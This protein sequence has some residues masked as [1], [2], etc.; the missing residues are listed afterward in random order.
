MR[1]LL[2]SFTPIRRAVLRHR[3]NRGP[4]S[5]S[6]EAAILRRLADELETN[7]FVE[8]GFHPAEFNCSLLLGDHAGLLIDGDRYV[9]EDARAVLTGRLKIKQQ[10]LT[11]ESMAA[12][13]REFLDPGIFSIDVD[14][15]DY[16]FLE[17]LLPYKPKV[18]C[19]EYNGSLLDHPISTPYDP[20]FDR[21]RKHPTGWYHGASLAALA[22]LCAAHG[23][24][25]EAVS[26]YGGNAFFTERGNLDPKAA[27]KPTLLRDNAS[28]RTATEQWAAIKDMPF[29]RV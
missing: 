9:V 18:I 12:I 28:R 29:E 26:L 8:F 7:S 1:A 11:R 21:S 4:T 23:Y 25:L 24:G 10:F 5:Q 3:M 14:G 2:K 6:D 22:K 15:N 13:G 20:E 17:A 27:W 16:W 19:V